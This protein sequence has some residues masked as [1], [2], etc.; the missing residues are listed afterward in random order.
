[1]IVTARPPSHRVSPSSRGAL[2]LPVG[3]PQHQ[4]TAARRC[5]RPG[6]TVTAKGEGGGQNRGVARHCH[7]RQ[8]AR[9]NPRRF[10]FP[11]S[12]P[13]HWS[14]PAKKRSSAFPAAR[15]ALARGCQRGRSPESTSP[16]GP[17]SRKA[18]PLFSLA[19]ATANGSFDESVCRRP[20]GQLNA[21]P[22]SCSRPSAPIQRLP[23]GGQD[24]RRRGRRAQPG[25]SGE[26]RSG[27]RSKKAIF[28]HH[29]VATGH[30]RCTAA[31]P[32]GERFSGANGKRP[33][34]FRIGEARVVIV[35]PARPRRRQTHS[36]QLRPAPHHRRSSS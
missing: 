9:P 22:S 2:P 17:N 25:R 8:D 32:Q 4:K 28:P 21:A 30:G 15:W 7:R 13:A 36:I 12:P 35:A 16:A 19:I 20:H 24:H 6:G 10:S 14:A 31:P 11:G 1:L 33:Q 18:Q 29:P 26:D 3:P 23:P 27:H 5:C 34:G